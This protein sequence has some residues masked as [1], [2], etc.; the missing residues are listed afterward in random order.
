MKIYIY[1]SLEKAVTGTSQTAFHCWRLFFLMGLDSNQIQRNGFNIWLELMDMSSEKHL[2]VACDAFWCGNKR[3]A[4][5]ARYP[6]SLLYSPAWH[7]VFLQ[8]QGTWVKKIKKYIVNNNNNNNSGGVS[9]GPWTSV[10]ISWS[11]PILDNNV[12]VCHQNNHITILYTYD[13]I[14][15]ELQTST[16]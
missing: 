2:S 10:S 5:C 16:V 6:E 13:Y 14:A 9:L 15:Q 1:L 8:L 3:K 7:F 4:L 12:K 11:I